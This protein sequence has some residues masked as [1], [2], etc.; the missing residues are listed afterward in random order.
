MIKSPFWERS[1]LVSS[2]LDGKAA[3][4]AFHRPG[5]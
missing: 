4:P 2:Q 3:P 5:I 1:G